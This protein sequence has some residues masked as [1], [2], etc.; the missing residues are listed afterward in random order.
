MDSAVAMPA[1]IYD[2]SAIRDTGK[3]RPVITVGGKKFASNAI[4]QPIQNPRTH[5]DEAQYLRLRE[6]VR[7]YGQLQPAIVRTNPGMKGLFR[8]VSGMSRRKINIELG[9][10]TWFEVNDS[11]G[12]NATEQEIAAIDN[13]VRE[14][15]AAMDLARAMKHSRDQLGRTLPQIMS[16]FGFRTTQTVSDYLGLLDLHPSVQQMLEATVPEKK[17]AA[18]NTYICHERGTL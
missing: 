15:L 17:T 10:R 7:T 16:I 6:S 14:G 5:Y 2:D 12:D 11:I 9:R 18:G 4:L 13:V 1:P 3:G 8:V